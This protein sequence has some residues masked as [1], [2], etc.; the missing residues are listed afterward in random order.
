[1]AAN[2]WFDSCTRKIELQKRV[3]DRLATD[4]QADAEQAIQSAEQARNRFALLTAAVILVSAG[5]AGGLMRSINVSVN[6]LSRTAR[7]VS[8]EGN[9]AVRA[10]KTTDDELGMLTDCFNQM[11]AQIEAHTLEFHSREA[12]LEGEVQA[13]TAE[14]REAQKSLVRT[15]RHAGMAEI[16]NGLIHN[17]G[18]ALNSVNVA[19]LSAEKMVR[20]SRSLQ[21]SRV[22]GLLREHRHHLPA[23][24]TQ[25]EKGRLVPA[26]VEELAVV[27]ADERRT[28]LDEF[29]VLT[30][31]IDHIKDIVNTQQAY[32]GSSSLLESI[33]PADVIDD[34]L[35]MNESALARHDVT[36]IREF[37]DLPA[38]S[39]DRHKLLQILL[40]LISNSKYALDETVGQEKR[41]TVRLE[42]FGDHSLRISVIDNGIGAT[43]EVL[44]KLFNY[45]F[46]TKK[47]GH[48]FGLHSCAIAAKS[49]G[50]SLTAHSEGQGRGA[51]F[52]LNLPIRR[53]QETCDPTA[54]LPVETSAAERRP[55]LVGG[56]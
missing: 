12:T 54:R 25:D 23:Y 50:G 5:L 33:K 52:V 4:L 39:L 13:R 46:T 40:N 15:A 34:A 1:V 47:C 38:V 6:H 22:A 7:Q 42:A 41:I 55:A 27:L 49:M 44:G 29:T 16:A 31:G 19:T 21:L 3:E 30:K 43:A 18:N 24:L 26:Y 2:H 14:L 53:V 56:D 48:G 8:F 51:T 35:R 45:G 10:K 11:L 28:L 20:D 32:A 9:Y 36:L 37:A 17:L